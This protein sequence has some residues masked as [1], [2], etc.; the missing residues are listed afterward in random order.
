MATIGD[1][2]DYI[3]KIAPFS[4]ADSWDNSGLLIGDRSAKVQNV[5][6]ALDA[7]I[8]VVN[9]AT[10]SRADLIVT[11]H[12]VIFKAL[13]NISG[14]GIAHRLIRGG[15]G[16]IS[17]HT[18]LDIADGG[19]NDVLAERFGLFGTKPLTVTQRENR[20]VIT[21]MVP[22]ESSEKLKSAMF[23]AGAGDFENYSECAFT[24]RGS[25]QFL[26]MNGANPAVGIVGIPEHITENQ[27]TMVCSEDKIKDVISALRMVHPYECPAFHV[28]RDISD[29]IQRGYGRIGNL[30]KSMSFCEFS[31]MVKKELACDRIRCYDSGREIKKVAVCGGSGGDMLKDAYNSG[32]DVLVTGDVQHHIYLE[33]QLYGISL[34]DAGHYNTEYVVI[35]KLADML[36]TKFVDVKFS[37]ANSECSPLNFK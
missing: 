23:N 32:C 10:K 3:D 29:S 1:I 2:Y 22:F 24:V 9:E 27:I 28:F 13:K 17:A 8:D 6:V 36:S 20:F 34:I 4:L 37:T 7:G 26:P 14:S 5:V 21:V 35:P 31:D 18:N 16:V 19:I 33:A 25:G 11:H 30:D 15:V 12:P